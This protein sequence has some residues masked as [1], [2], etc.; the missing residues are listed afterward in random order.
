VVIAGPEEMTALNRQYL[1]RD[2]AANVLS[3]PM[4]EGPGGDLNP[5]L[6]GDVVICADTAKRE[7]DEAGVSFSRRMR[8]LLIHGVLHL[9]GHDHGEPGEAARMEAEEA[10]LLALAEGKSGEGAP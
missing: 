8:E 3:F 6:L 7:A 10:R 9:M 4:R 2:Y 1:D 5:E